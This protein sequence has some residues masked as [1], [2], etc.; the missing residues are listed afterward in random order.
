MDLRSVPID[1]GAWH[2]STRSGDNSTCVEAAIVPGLVVGVRDT[3]DRSG[4]ELRFT[5]GAWQA[6][7]ADVKAGVY[8]L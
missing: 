7:L 5:P 1:D 8:D 3:K 4:G 2:K 6:F